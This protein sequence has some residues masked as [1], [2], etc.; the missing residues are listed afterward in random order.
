MPY[1][2]GSTA[3]GVVHVSDVYY[4]PNVFANNVNVALWNPQGGTGAY[5]FSASVAPVEIETLEGTYI[6]EKLDGDGIADPSPTSD[7]AEQINQNVSDGVSSGVLSTAS[8]STTV[9]GTPDTTAP[10]EPSGKLITA[11]WNQFN[12]DNIPYDSLMLTPKTSLAEFTKKAAL[13]K[14]QPSPP[15]PDT[16]YTSNNPRNGDN[17]YIRDQDI[18]V[19]KKKT[20]YI[21][22]PQIL[23]NLS[24]LASNIWEPFKAKYPTAIVTN[25]FRQNPPGGSSAQAQHGMGMAMDIQLLDGTPEKY[26]E[27]AKWIR[28]NLPFDQLL[29]EKSGSSRWLHVSHYSGYGYKVPTSSRVANLIVSPSY[30]FVTGLS[31]LT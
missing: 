13:W 4:S 19:N 31:L 15:G 16:P 21:T 14:N 26:L 1:K 28:D 10:P 3:H 5:A 11:D 22:V 8:T 24:N 2:P 27:A 25:T 9:V 18:I 6:Q 30:S 12:K 17:K 23:H 20:G 29:Q 7:Q